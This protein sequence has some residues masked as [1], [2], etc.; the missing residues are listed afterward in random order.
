MRAAS[1]L[2]IKREIK[3]EKEELTTMVKQTTPSK[4][5]SNMIWDNLEEMV[6]MR[7]RDYIQKL[8]EAEVEE[9]LGRQKSERR[10][11]VDSPLAYRN[12]H[13][14]DRKLTL[15]LPECR[16]DG[17]VMKLSAGPSPSAVHL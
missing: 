3:I 8:M 5:S 10:K 17:D 12:G 15:G 6:R 7:V 1:I 13:G 9:L 2:S 16:A 11:M 14:K 4:E